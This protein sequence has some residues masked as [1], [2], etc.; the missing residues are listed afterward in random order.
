[1]RYFLAVMLFLPFAGRAQFSATD[2]TRYKL[3]AQRVTIIRDNWGVP[4]IYGKSDADAVFGLMYAQCEENFNQVEANTIE[5]LGRSAEYK[6]EG[7]LYEDLQMQLI[8]DTSA[9]K[10]D[11][12]KAPQ[13]LKKLTDAYADGVNYYLYLHPE[14]KAKLLRRFEP[15]FAL[16]RTDG[17]IS[18]TQTGGL[19]MMDMSAMYKLQQA[20][21]FLS[22]ATLPV[23]ADL[24]GSNGFAVAPSRT[25]S[26]H[27]IL[28]I[29]PHTTF[30]YRTEAHMVSEEGLNVYG[31]VTWGTFF[32]YQGF[33]EYCGWMHTTS[34]ADVADLFAEEVDELDGNY[35]FK[36]DGRL[37]PVTKTTRVLKYRKGD[38]ILQQS[39]VTYATV[40]GPVVGKRD[41]RWLSLKENN[42]SLD[43]LIQ[44]WNRTKARG[45]EDF[46]KVMALR[47][48]NSN[49]TVFADSKGNIAY[50]HGNFMPRRNPEYDYSSIVEGNVSA[51]N[52]KGLHSV[53]ET[54]H[55]YNPSSGWIQNCNSTP[56]TAAGNSS[57]KRESYPVYMAPDGEN[58][59]GI[60]AA[61]LLELY[62]DLTIDKMID[63]I[64]YN[65]YLPIFD[66]LMQ[67]LN[68][69][70]YMLPVNDSLKKRL[71]EPVQWLLAW[72]RKSSANSEEATLAIEWAYKILQRSLPASNPYK[73]SDALGQLFITLG[74]LNDRQL[75]VLLDET[76]RDLE[77]GFGTWKVAWG[78]MNRYQRT[79]GT[80][81]D[82]SAPSLPS[83]LAAGNF[84]SL[85]AYYSV[86]PKGNLM[87]YGTSGNSF[88]ACVEF[89]PRIKAKSV[90]TGGQSYDPSS[91]HYSDQAQMF[92]EGKFKD[93]NFY[94]ED[95]MRNKERQYHPGE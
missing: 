24:T 26:K 18:A 11:Y 41:G 34:G 67:A 29:N 13:W 52:W 87:R 37:Q 30:F 12:Q 55:I 23:E 42:R 49:N 90:I 22:S 46:K 74:I 79:N 72:D 1:M 83:G 43:A 58:F 68:T 82:D 81:P 88:V 20:S 57:P 4:H 53:D 51:S 44:S 14:A 45:F 60:N 66:Y 91:K 64:G 73:R 19:S 78:E 56:F 77:K 84:G 38:S 33:N 63:S 65:R 70:F 36:Y 9:A 71:A 25:A 59:R 95:V 7:A 17:S 62:S 61:R 10:T 6:G 47:A 94:R 69:S 3:T 89:G 54:V 85:P 32:V 28:Y 75:M 15:W 93:V 76:M 16:L 39:L 80:P 5:M 35:F 27:A 2:I 40:H 31:G 50:W 8:Y 48:N 21:S 86:R 92:L